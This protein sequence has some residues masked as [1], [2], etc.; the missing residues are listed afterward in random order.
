M[1]NIQRVTTHHLA[2]Q[3]AN[4]PDNRRRVLRLIPARDGRAWHVDEE[5]NHWRAYHFIENA[6]T[7]DAVE[8]TEQAFQAARAFGISSRLLV[9]LPAPRLHD[10]IP[11][12]HHTPKRFAL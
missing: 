1:E 9:G 10:T 8:S 4:E 3:V 7:Y 6:R 5:G 11:D 12:F 2:A